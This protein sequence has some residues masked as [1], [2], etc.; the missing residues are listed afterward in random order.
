MA[1]WEFY[2]DQDD[3]DLNEEIVDREPNFHDFK[4]WI[5]S[6]QDS[7]IEKEEN[8]DFNKDLLKEEF[9]NRVKTRVANKINKRLG[10]KK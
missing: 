1:R 5:D 8:S 7:L 6:H 10:E 3:I 9:K 4:K 2:D